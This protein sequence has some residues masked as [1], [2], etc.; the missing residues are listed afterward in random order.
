LIAVNRC[1]PQRRL[2]TAP[3]YGGFAPAFYPFGP[4]YYW[5]DPYGFNYY[6]PPVAVDQNGTLY[7]DYVNV[8]PHVMGTIDFGLIAH[9]RLVAEV[10]DVGTF[11]PHVEIKHQ[12]GLDPNVFPLR[13][14]LARCVPLHIAFKDGTPPWT[15]PNLPAIERGI[16]R[17]HQ[18]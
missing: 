16:Y 6:Q 15:N 5:R 13:T 18:H 7:L 4:A 9:G 12:F 2:S 10:R 1:D 8:T 17:H 3:V 14:A 11:S